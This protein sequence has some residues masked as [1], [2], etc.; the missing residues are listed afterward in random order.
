MQTYQYTAISRT[1]R[2]VTGV[3]EATDEYAA[4]AKIKENYPTIVKIAPAPE[5]KARVMPRK[6]KEKELSVL[7]SQFAIILSAGIP[8]VRTIDLIAQQTADRYLQSALRTVAE[9][10]G[11]GSTLTH[12]FEK[13]TGLF[14]PAFLETVRSGEESGTLETSF[15]RLE[16]YYKKAAQ[17][18]G[19]MQTAMT[20]PVFTLVIAA[21]VVAV[22]M[23]KAVP[24]FVS[25]FQ[26]MNLELPLP[27]VILIRT[28]NFFTRYWALLAFVIVLAVLLWR[29][30]GH[31]R[32]GELAESRF[33]MRVPILGRLR[34]TRLSAQFAS[35]LSTLLAAGVP[36]IRALDQ[37]AQVIDEAVVSRY[38]NT[39][40]PRLN[41]GRTLASCLRM[42]PFL[43]PLLVEMTGIGEETGT[44]ESTLETIGDYYDNETEMA[45]QRIISL[46]EPIIICVLAIVVLLILLAVYLPMFSLYGAM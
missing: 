17:S 25:T 23:V 8:V 22:L 19:K 7:C 40:L 37:T 10:V 28:S 33:R 36:L 34:V 18:R 38:L 26:D 32:R 27:T 24:V 15:Q 35:T 5:K 29:L 44:L 46:M 13:Q 45:S 3:V 41:E 42:C 2:K 14:P 20:Y 21:L 1:K 16:R 11:A 12:A 31:T 9:D 39:Q 43:P 4:V 6:I 30:W